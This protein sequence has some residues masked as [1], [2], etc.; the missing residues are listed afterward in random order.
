MI[1]AHL[2]SNGDLQKAIFSRKDTS[3][4]IKL[5]AENPLGYGDRHVRDPNSALVTAN[6]DIK[7]CELQQIVAGGWISTIGEFALIIESSRLRGYRECR[8]TD[9]WEDR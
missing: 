6:G 5:G 7:K 8:N 1:L 9:Q 4:K 3:A 2:A